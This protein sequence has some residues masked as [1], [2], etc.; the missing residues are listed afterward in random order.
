[1]QA[2]QPFCLPAFEHMVSRGGGRAAAAAAAVAAAARVRTQQQSTRA[3]RV[4]ARRT[5]RHRGLLQM[6][7]EASHTDP[8]RPPPVTA[9]AARR[10]GRIMGCRRWGAGQ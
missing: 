10:P 3:P 6:L 1:M 8:L 4:K 7:A 2:T 9:L 5:V